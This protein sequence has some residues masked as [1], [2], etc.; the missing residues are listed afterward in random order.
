[1][2]ITHVKETEWQNWVLFFDL[3]SEENGVINFRFCPR[4]Y[5]GRDFLKGFEFTFQCD[6]TWGNFYQ[7]VLM[8][9]EFIKAF[10]GQYRLSFSPEKYWFKVIDN[11][12]WLGGCPQTIDA[13]DF[14]KLTI[15]SDYHNLVVSIV[16]EMLA[17][18]YK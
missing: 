8:D 7:K 13:Y 10:W 9:T 14:G 5:D 12:G 11:F 6:G 16:G 4:P 15:P 17:W 1:M 18:D 2:K 3:I